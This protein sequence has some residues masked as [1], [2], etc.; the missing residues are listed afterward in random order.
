MVDRA[1]ASAAAVA[2]LLF[3][4]RRAGQALPTE[5][6]TRR[7]EEVPD[8]LWRGV[9]VELDG[10]DGVARAYV[11]SLARLFLLPAP[12]Q[13]VDPDLHLPDVLVRLGEGPHPE[14]VRIQAR[15]RGQP[16]G[17]RGIG[18]H[19]KRLHDLVFEESV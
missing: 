9:D 12:L 8:D 4:A 18:G 17:Q 11:R 6:S 14:L 13:V 5:P 1:R 16:G 19:A 15:L 7:R 10:V 2:G 3:D